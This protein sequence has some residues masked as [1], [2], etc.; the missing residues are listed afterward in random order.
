MARVPQSTL[1]RK[2]VEEL[3]E[4]AV[5]IAQNAIF[6]DRHIAPRDGR[7]TSMIFMPLGFLDR[8]QLLH[9]QR[10]QRPG[11]IYAKMADAGPRAVN[12]YPMFFTCSMLHPD[13]ATIVW[14]RYTE[15]MSLMRHDTR[16][17][18]GESPESP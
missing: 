16:E 13:D 11:L 9:L 4:I 6:T 8:K 5:G 3:H 17:A 7:M 18:E 2:P 12:G 15:I 10:K 1:P 14:A